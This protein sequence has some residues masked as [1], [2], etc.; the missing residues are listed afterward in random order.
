M[1][2]KKKGRGCPS[3]FSCEFRRDAVALVL[4]EDRSSAGVARSLGVNE[5]TL[6]NWARLERI[7]RGE[8]DAMTVDERGELV[9][10]RSEDAKLGMERD[11]LKRSLALWVKETSTP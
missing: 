3:K 9:E 10:L 1:S 8:R 6:G 11:L 7:E 4:D 2:T 5:G